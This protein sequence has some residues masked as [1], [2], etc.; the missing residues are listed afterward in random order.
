MCFSVSVQVLHTGQPH[1]PAAVS[2][3]SSSSFVLFI[4]SRHATSVGRA[5]GLHSSWRGLGLGSGRRS[6]HLYWLLLC[7][8]QIY[9][10]LLQR[11]RDHL[12]CHPQSGV[13][14]L[15][16]YVGCHVRWRWVVVWHSLSSLRNAPLNQQWPEIVIWAI[17]AGTVERQLVPNYPILAT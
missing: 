11:D 1:S 2:S 4:S 7:L 9:H 5:C 3:S 10:S 8:S 17:S 14:D 15:L 12:R 16:H 13:V 6:L